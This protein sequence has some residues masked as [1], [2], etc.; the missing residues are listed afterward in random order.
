MRP[1]R[2][3]LTLALVTVLVLLLLKHEATPPGDPDPQP[4]QASSASAT[5]PVSLKHKPN[6]P[7]STGSLPLTSPDQTVLP[8]D[9][10]RRPE[11]GFRLLFTDGLPVESAEITWSARSTVWHERVEQPSERDW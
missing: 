10:H 9:Q 8:A 11:S 3:L 4:T 6:A 7:D 1:L 5:V 2:S